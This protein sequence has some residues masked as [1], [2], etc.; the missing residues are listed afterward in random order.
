MTLA[1]KTFLHLS[2]LTVVMLLAGAAAIWC[3]L[4]LRN[5][6]A[7]TREEF[8]E[9]REI[10]PVERKLSE[11]WLHIDELNRAA[12]A[13]GL[14]AA[15]ESLDEFLSEQRGGE[16][17]LDAR[18]ASD[19]QRLAQQTRTA[20]EAL[21]D[22]LRVGPPAPISV[23]ESRLLRDAQSNLAELI[24]EFERAVALVHARTTRRF[25]LVLIGLIALFGAVTLAAAGMNLALFRSVIGPLRYI[26]DGVRKLAGGAL[27]TRLEPRGDSEFTDLQTDFNTMAQELESLYRDLERRVAEQGRRLAVSERLAS[28]GFL[29]AGVAHEINNPLAIMSG[30]AQ[31]LLRRLRQPRAANRDDSELVR[32]LEIIRDEAFRAKRITR[33]LLDL[34]S[35]G[36]AQRSSLSL[37]RVID[38]VTSILRGSVYCDGV[39]LETVGDKADPLVVS[40]SEPEIKQVVLNL[41]MN[42]AQAVKHDHGHVELRARRQ[43]GWVELQVRDDGCGMTPEMIEH[44]FEPFY[45][46]RKGSGGHGL[47]LTI[48]HAIVRRHDGELLAESDGPGRGSVFTLRLPAAREEEP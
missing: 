40:G 19:E 45:S 20:L 41:T 7:T 18:H 37:W 14:D 38:D 34:S 5:L 31:S 39:A 44:V 30:Y 28:V 10:R 1:R 48:S 6:N 11:A 8:E 23:E 13:Q 25:Q 4:M 47:G 16:S 3:L 35:G 36:D 17:R 9:L 43:N 32:D 21:R 42:A 46:G 12:V 2:A 24:D 29:A 33:Q 27:Q 26:R 22:Q 15:L